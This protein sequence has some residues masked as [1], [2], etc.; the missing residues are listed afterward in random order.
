MELLPDRLPLVIGVTGHRDLRAEDRPRLEQEVAAVLETLRRDYLPDSDTPVVMLSA[1]AEGADQLVTRVA[2]AHGARLIAPLPLPPEEYRR[3]FEPGLAPGAAQEFDRL[4]AQAETAPVMPFADGASLDSVRANPDRRAQQYRSVGAFIVQHCHVLIAL[5]DGDDRDMAPGGTAEIVDCKRNG[6]PPSVTGS[7]RAALD[8]SEI[9]PV[10]HVV[11]P[12][13]KNP[14]VAIEVRPWGKAAI[15]IA[16][17]KRKRGHGQ[18]VPTPEEREAHAWEAFIALNKLTARYNKEA[19]ELA[20]RADG[21]GRKRKSIADLFWTSDSNKRPDQEAAVQRAIATAPR[22]CAV[23]AAADVLAQTWQKRFRSDWFHLFLLGVGALA[24][25]ELKAH[26]FHHHVWLLIAYGVLL[27]TL[28]GLLR[29]ALLAQHQERFLDYRAL[30]EALRVAT[31][32]K[33]AGVGTGRMQ[34][35][36]STSISSAYPIKQPSELAWVKV[37]LRTLELLDTV[38][39]TTAAP[40]ALDRAGYDWLRNLWIGGQ[41]EYFTATSHSYHR[42]AEIREHISLVLLFMSPVIAAA[43]LYFYYFG[44]GADPDSIWHYDGPGHH[45]LVFGIGVLA[46]V[47]AAIVGYTEQLALKAQARQYDRMRALFERAHLVLPEDFAATTP[48]FA[49]A[50]FI[51]IGCEAMKE[52]AEWV[53]IYRQRPIRA[54]QG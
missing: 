39:E 50:M 28:F 2:L 6:I 20:A 43:L 22:W 51:E 16:R 26:F 49:Q 47:A 23:Y 3:D 21:E 46:A 38:G 9:G 29:F 30:A 45:L 48:Q 44:G 11:T 17:D 8:A 25:F 15:R 13:V 41:L 52:N 1:L 36:A 31:Y 24:V 54:P 32:W 34:D 5:W 40:V 14:D 12:R 27:L 10:I 42:T 35:D 18:V 53:S 37:C 4:L 19:A 33:L 7:A